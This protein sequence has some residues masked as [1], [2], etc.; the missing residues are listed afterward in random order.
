MQRE[1]LQNLGLSDEQVQAVLTQ[2]GKSTNEIK[3]KLAQAEEQVTDLQNQISD[4]DKQLKNLEKTVGDNQELAQEIDK[5]RKE[6]EQTAKDY[7][8]KITKQAKDF[9]I[10][11]ALKDAGAKN[12]K[13]TRALLDMD[14]VS[15]GEDGQLFGIAEQLDELQ[16]TDAYLFAQKQEEKKPVN[17]FAGGILALMFLKILK[18]CH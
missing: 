17:L 4:R 14:K 15:V 7:Q 18:T 2:H 1:F 9:A 6:N 10:S 11:N 8:S 16:K 5:L 12:I 3:G 13:A